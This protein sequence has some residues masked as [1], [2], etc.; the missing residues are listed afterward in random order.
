MS[1]KTTS[2]PDKEQ[3]QTGSIPEQMR[4]LMSW[5]FKNMWTEKDTDLKTRSQEQKQK[6]S[7]ILTTSHVDNLNEALMMVSIHFQC[8]EE[9]SINTLKNASFCFPQTN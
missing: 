1:T 7:I 4:E 8:I 5:L 9:S 3:K 6:Q 2:R